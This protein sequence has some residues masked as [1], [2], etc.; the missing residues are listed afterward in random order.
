MWWLF[1]LNMIFIMD[2]IENPY[3]FIGKGNGSFLCRYCF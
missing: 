3:F 1:N 2:E